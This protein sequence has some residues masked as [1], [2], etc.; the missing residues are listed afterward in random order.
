MILKSVMF[1]NKDALDELTMA[2]YD[3]VTPDTVFVCIGTDRNIADSLGPLVG[4][5][6]EKEGINVYGTLRKPVHAQNIYDASLMLY[7][8]HS[9]NNIIAIDASLGSEKGSI[10]VKDEPV[11][12]GAGVKKVL[13]PIGHYSIAGVT[14]NSIDDVI[15]N[16]TSAIRINFIMEMAEVISEA[17]VRAIRIKTYEET[18]SHY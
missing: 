15:N 18:Y 8:Q 6:L 16:N 9:D 2:L 10:R 5:L 13:P 4:H 7:E 12:P 14:C 17:I 1:D 11:R 3:I